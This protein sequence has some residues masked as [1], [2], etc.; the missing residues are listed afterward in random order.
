M[1]RRLQS[2]WPFR[3]FQGFFPPT[4]L[5]VFRLALSAKKIRQSIGFLASN[6]S[7]IG[8]SWQTKAQKPY[9]FLF[10]CH[11]ERSAAK[12]YF[13]SRSLARSRRAPTECPLPC[14]TREF[15]RYCLMSRSSSAISAVKVISNFVNVWHLWQL[16]RSLA[17][18]P[19]PLL[20]LSS[21]PT[22][23]DPEPAKGKRVGVEV[24]PSCGR[25]ARRRNPERS[26][27]S[28]AYPDDDSYHHAASGSSLE[29][30]LILLPSRQRGIA[31]SIHF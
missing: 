12:M 31:R 9:A 1:A 18:V 30:H 21:W 3:V 19:N 28:S 25:P 11:P 4:P 5:S 6:V 29:A 22:T 10:T 17:H 2:C 15:S 26:R 23:N 14:R 13:H 8:T 7:E 20:P 16:T 24:E 27:G